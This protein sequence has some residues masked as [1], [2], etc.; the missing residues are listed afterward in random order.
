MLVASAFIRLVLRL[1]LVMSRCWFMMRL[2]L[3]RMR[4]MLLLNRWWLMMVWRGLMIALTTTLLVHRRRRTR[5]ITAVVLLRCLLILP[6]IG[7]LRVMLLGHH[8]SS[9]GLIRV[10]L[11]LLLRRLRLRR[12]ILRL[13]GRWPA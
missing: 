1:L 12:R 3:S 10:L 4:L 7:S 6:M 13:T 8:T 2:I 9:S 11:G 5:V